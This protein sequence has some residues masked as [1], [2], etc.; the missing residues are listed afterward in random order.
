MKKLLILLLIVMSSSTTAEEW[1]TPFSEGDY[2]R[3]GAFI[4]LQVIDWQQT[5][6]ISRNCDQFYEKSYITSRVIG[7]CPTAQGVDRYMLTGAVLHTL[8][9]YALPVKYMST[10]QYVTIGVTGIAVI[11]N[12]QLGIKVSF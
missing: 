12:Y 1:F 8:V 9:S 3:E 4:G 10:W 5:L 6:T 7:S 2:Y 11:Q